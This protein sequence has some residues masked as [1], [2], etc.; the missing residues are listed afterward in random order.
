MP[1]TLYNWFGWLVWLVKIDFVHNDHHQHQH[2]FNY[3]DFDYSISPRQEEKKTLRE[4]CVCD[5]MIIV[6][7][8]K[9]E[10]EI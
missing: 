9:Q 3:I 1:N 7:E 8:R 5:S 10:R 2:H 4:K 6:E